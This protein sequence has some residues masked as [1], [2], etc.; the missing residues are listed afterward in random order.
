M[1]DQVYALQ[2]AEKESLRE[3]EEILAQLGRVTSQAVSTEAAGCSLQTQLAAATA[4]YD[5]EKAM[6][7]QCKA[8][9][10]ALEGELRSVREKLEKEQEMMRGKLSSAD[11]ISTM[12][13]DACRG[14]YCTALCVVLHC[15]VLYSSLL[16]CAVLN[17][18]RIKY[19]TPLHSVLHEST[20]LYSMRHCLLS[21]FYSNCFL[22]MNCYSYQ[23]AS[24]HL[25]LMF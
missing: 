5:V 25:Q 2:N 24:T 17:C 1:E 12:Q 20:Q 7:K 10:A 21:I 8:T 16:Y 4:D 18:T 22:S 14:M 3:K 11:S 23:S 9:L 19:S 13:S 15:T 6:H